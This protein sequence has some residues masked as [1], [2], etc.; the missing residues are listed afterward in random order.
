MRV[1][2]SVSKALAFIFTKETTISKNYVVNFITGT[3]PVKTMPFLWR[4]LTF[5]VIKKCQFL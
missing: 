3:L 1:K 2:T 4:L 5:P